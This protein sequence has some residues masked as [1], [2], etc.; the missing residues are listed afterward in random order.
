MK[1]NV[2]KSVLNEITALEFKRDENNIM[3]EEKKAKVL[4][5]EFENIAAELRTILNPFQ[6]GGGQ[7]CPPNR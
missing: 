3:N 7:I 1:G 2:K 5:G 4:N 6:I